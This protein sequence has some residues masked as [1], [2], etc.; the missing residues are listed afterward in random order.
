MS[1]IQEQIK[2]DNERRTLINKCS[3]FYF[4]E[5]SEQNPLVSPSFCHSVFENKTVKE[6]K[7]YIKTSISLANISEKTNNLY[8]LL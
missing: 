5:M 7:K 2:K 8:I 1:N 3:S 6:L 4:N